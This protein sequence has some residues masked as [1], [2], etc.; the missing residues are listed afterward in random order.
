MV[1]AIS[2]RLRQQVMIAADYRCEYCK[3][4]ARIT[5]TPLVIDHVFPQSLGGE[6]DV[7]NLAAACY[8]CNLLKNN[9]TQ[10]QDVETGEQTRLFNPRSDVWSEHFAWTE[11]GQLLVG[12]T[13]IGR[14]TVLA[15]RLNNDNLVVARSLWIAAGWHPPGT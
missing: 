11:G 1:M 9:K 3:A 14:V 2:D 15:L 6:D 4:S 13:A 10:V 5:G 8:R 12:L 7:E